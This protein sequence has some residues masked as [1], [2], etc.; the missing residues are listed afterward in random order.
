MWADH[1]EAVQHFCRVQWGYCI[2]EARAERAILRQLCR[3]QLDFENHFL[4][5]YKDYLRHEQEALDEPARR[6]ACE[7]LLKI[8]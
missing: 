4:S 6:F 8:R 1:L 5:I 7:R 2:P 3:R